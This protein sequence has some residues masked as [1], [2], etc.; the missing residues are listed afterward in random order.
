M[1]ERSKTLEDKLAQLT[2]EC[3]AC[4]RGRDKE[5]EA[6]PDTSQP[7]HTLRLPKNQSPNSSHCFLSVFNRRQSF[8]AAAKELQRIFRHRKQ[9]YREIGI[10]VAPKTKLCGAPLVI[11]S[12]PEAYLF[13]EGKAVAVTVCK[14]VPHF[15]SQHHLSGSLVPQ[16]GP[17][18]YSC[19]WSPR[20]QEE[21]TESPAGVER[22]SIHLLVWGT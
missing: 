20:A 14:E 16:R 5:V 6:K 4:Q 22:S 9:R 13:E 21:E 12:E 10:R 8:W 1:R 7:N 3:A 2:E 19:R 17:S 18:V 11:S 15:S